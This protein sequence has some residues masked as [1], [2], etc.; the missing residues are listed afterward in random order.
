MMMEAPTSQEPIPAEL[1]G[2]FLFEMTVQFGEGSTQ[3]TVG[4]GGRGVRRVAPASGGTF[5]GSHLSGKLLGPLPDYIVARPDGVT[6]HDI[7]AVLQ[8][9]DGALI[10]MEYWG[11]GHRLSLGPVGNG[12]DGDFYFRVA[13]RFETSAEQYQWLNRVL[14]V[15]VFQPQAQRA[16]GWRVYA[17]R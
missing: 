5:K 3:T 9:N 17:I 11:I 10:Y 13:C 2:E 7:R 16:V 6:E 8:T 1:R 4:E 14:A 15:G 12:A